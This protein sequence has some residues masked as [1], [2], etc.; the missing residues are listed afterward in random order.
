MTHLAI[1]MFGDPEMSNF[2]MWLFL[3]VGAVALFCVFIPLVTWLDSRRK[4][5]EA[6]YKS[7][8]IRRLAEAPGDAAKTAL[9]LLREEDRLKRL[10]MLEGLKIG[11]L[12]NVGVGVGLII[13][14]RSL[15]GGGHGSPF[16]CGLIPAMCG[17]GM[18]VYAFFMA[19]PVEGPR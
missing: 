16:L 17:V 11:G 10:K 4:E 18:L 14:L 2:G 6:Y 5:R 15:L 3:S 12:I 1:S 13:F 9:E 19:A 7:E 8:N